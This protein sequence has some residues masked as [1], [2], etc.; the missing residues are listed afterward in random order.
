MNKA[1]KNCPTSFI[2]QPLKSHPAPNYLTRPAGGMVFRELIAIFAWKQTLNQ[3]MTPST[4]F[5]SVAVCCLAALL[6]VVLLL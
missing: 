5:I 4:L 3:N 6:A 2:L 1:I